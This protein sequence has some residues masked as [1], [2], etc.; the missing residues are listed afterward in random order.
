MLGKGCQHKQLATGQRA[1]R[2]KSSLPNDA[3]S[4]HEKSR[5]RQK[6]SNI[7][8]AASAAARQGGQSR[9]LRLAGRSEIA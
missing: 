6:K 2:P 9:L 8:V 1:A 3:K 4:G 7:L 5:N